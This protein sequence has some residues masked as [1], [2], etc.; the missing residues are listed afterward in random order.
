MPVGGLANKLDVV[1]W[2][3]ASNREIFQNCLVACL[4]GEGEGEGLT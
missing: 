3:E 4:I 1:K 2:W